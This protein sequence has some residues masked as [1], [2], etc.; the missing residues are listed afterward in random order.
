M[1]TSSTE[2]VVVVGGC[3]RVGLPFSISLANSGYEVKAL[4][5][6]AMKVKQVNQGKMPFMETNGN[7]F[8]QDALEGKRFSATTDLVSV[9]E[10]N[11]VVIVIGTPIDEFQNPDVKGLFQL[12]ESL[13][14]YMNESQ[15]ILLRSTV[16]P[17][18]TAKVENLLRNTIPNVE[19]AYC[20][21]RIVEGN[22]FEELTA[23]PQIIGSRTKVAFDKARVIFDKLSIEAMW[24]TPE[25]AEL[26]KLFSN[27]WR[28]IKFAVANQFWVIS[29][30]L[31]IDFT[32]VHK[33]VTYKYPRGQDLPLPG[34]TAGP[35]LYKDTMQLASLMKLNFPLGSAAVSINEG[36][37]SYLV[38]KLRE[39]YNLRELRVGILGVAFKG[40]I[41]DIRSSLA[42][43]L[44]KV[45]LIE[46]KEVVMSDPYVVDM[47]LKSQDEVLETSDILII[48][49]PHSVY[50]SL[51]LNK[52]II[53]IWN[54][55]KKGTL[56]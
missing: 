7:R 30:D 32:N 16:F 14:D 52:P 38:A 56:I 8:L 41:D 2:K 46:A 18:V 45:L 54:M 37:P 35:C 34:F 1:A 40:D 11:I 6:D 44:R 9:A 29:N 19:L 47:R 13:L 39:S 21:E 55:Q 48:G 28:Y 50:R 51:R 26:A 49:C 24:V 23:I 12:L 3:G 20:P 22:A 43:K 42:F 33:A 27:A 4:D 36:I 17:G 15:L 10:A 25:E 31:D 53:D 5:I